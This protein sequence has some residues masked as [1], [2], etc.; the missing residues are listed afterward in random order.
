MRMASMLASAAGNRQALYA[1]G[2][3]IRA[4]TKL[5]IVCRRQ[6][7]KY[8]DQVTRNRHLA[9]RIA[10]LATH[11]PKAGSAAAVIA[12]DEID[13]GADEIRDIEALLDIRDQCVRRISAG[14]EVQVAR[15]GRRRGGDPPL[16]VTGASKSKLARGCAIE[17]PRCQHAIL[18]DGQRLRG[19]AFGVERTRAQ[20]APAQRVVD[21]TDARLEQ[22]FAEL[23]FQKTRAASNR[24]AVDRTGKMAD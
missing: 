18:H 24:R 22:P 20:A 7:L 23:V 12:G 19:Y 15:G 21:H 2:R 17:K 3:R 6:T 8:V 9:H 16:G 14:H 4:E 13:A 10:A 11:D 1:Q 5:E